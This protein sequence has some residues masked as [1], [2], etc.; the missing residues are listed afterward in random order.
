MEAQK[1][2]LQRI[3]ANEDHVV[4]FETRLKLIER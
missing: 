4:D 2:L 1:M 3:H